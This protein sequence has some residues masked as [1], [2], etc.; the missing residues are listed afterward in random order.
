MSR[1]TEI[2]ILF[3]LARYYFF[4]WRLIIRI[5]G[6]EGSRVQGFKDARVRGYVC[7]KIY[8]TLYYPRLLGLLNPRTLEPL[9]FLIH[10]DLQDRQLITRQGVYFLAPAGGTDEGVFLD[11]ELLITGRTVAHERCY[12]HL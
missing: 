4:R 11:L 9:P 5:Q 1:T 10:L 8:A 12:V 2:F 3:F 6:F 7:Y